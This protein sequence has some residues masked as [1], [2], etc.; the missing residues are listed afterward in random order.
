MVPKIVV[1]KCRLNSE[2]EWNYAIMSETDDN[3]VF[4]DAFDRLATQLPKEAFLSTFPA[5]FCS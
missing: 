3:W 4:H 1:S 5:L 2:R